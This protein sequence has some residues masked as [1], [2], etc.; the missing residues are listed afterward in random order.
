MHGKIS[1]VSKALRNS[2]EIVPDFGA[3]VFSFTSPDKHLR[4]Q[5]NGSKFRPE[6]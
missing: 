3:L 5:A 1:G 6:H 2:G 4:G